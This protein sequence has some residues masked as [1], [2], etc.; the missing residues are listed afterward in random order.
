MFEVP[1][2]TLDILRQ[3]AG[4]NPG[5]EV[6]LIRTRHED[7]SEADTLVVEM[8]VD[9]MR[10][11]DSKPVLALVTDHVQRIVSLQGFSKSCHSQH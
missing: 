3:I 11:E 8:A 4:V 7:R 10:N 9:G 2:L 6:E 1:R 5:V